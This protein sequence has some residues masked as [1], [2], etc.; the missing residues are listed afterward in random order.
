[1][2][3]NLQIQR[4]SAPRLTV[5]CAMI[6]QRLT[7]QR[8]RQRAAVARP[9]PKALAMKTI[10]AF[11]SILFFVGNSSGDV[12][13]GENLN[14]PF[15]VHGRFRCYPCGGMPERIWI[16]GS[17]RVLSVEGELTPALEKIRKVMGEDRGWFA[18]DIFADFTV[19]PLAADI[20]GHMRPVRIVSIKRVVIATR[21]GEVL[22]MRDEL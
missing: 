22:A 14:K 7:S 15:T 3:P 19:E 21:E 10:L 2:V 4:M 6:S 12:F 11:L 16:V 5:D 8:R 1:M 9:G 17:K 18:R 13:T 20:K